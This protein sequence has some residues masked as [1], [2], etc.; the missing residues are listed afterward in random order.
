MPF[1]LALRHKKRLATNERDEPF[2][3]EGNRS[4]SSAPACA[5]FQGLGRYR[6]VALVMEDMLKNPPP[7][8]VADAVSLALI[9][10]WMDNDCKKCKQ[11]FWRGS[12]WP[13]GRLARFVTL[14][15]VALS[16]I[17]CDR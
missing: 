13:P 16:A 5:G 6:D 10:C 12:R 9:Q 17:R 8:P 2:N 3:G 4:I 14:V 7:D 1:C 11:I 15:P